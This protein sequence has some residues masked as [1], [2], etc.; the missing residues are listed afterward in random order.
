MKIFLKLVLRRFLSKICLKTT[1]I[2]NVSK[3]LVFE[4]KVKG[5]ILLKIIDS[6]G[7]NGQM[8]VFPQKNDARPVEI[9]N[10]KKQEIVFFLFKVLLILF[11]NILGHVQY[12]HLLYSL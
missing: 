6:I 12:H 8:I 1:L 2:L 9:K 5:P 11:Q 3:T 7:K 4:N 10:I